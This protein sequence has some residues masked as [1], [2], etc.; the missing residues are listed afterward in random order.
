MS[1]T[2]CAVMSH[3][4]AEFFLG[5]FFVSNGFYDIGTGNEHVAGLFDHYNEVGDGRRVHCAA[6]ARPHNCRN[7]GNH[8]RSNG[9]SQKNIGVAGQRYYAF[10]NSRAAGV[11]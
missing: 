10:L 11:V 1:H 9:V 5:D 4:A 2:A 3:G 7:L 6:G 8:T